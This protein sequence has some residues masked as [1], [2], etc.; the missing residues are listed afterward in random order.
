MLSKNTLSLFCDL[1]MNL[2][3]KEKQVEISRQ[4]LCHNLNFDAYQVFSYLDCES[5]NY[6]NEINLMTFLQKKN[7][8]P[9]T[10]EELQFFILLYDENSDAKL[11]YS[12]FLNI[13]LS[14]NN[15]ELRKKTRERI[16]SCYD[17]STIEFNIE[18]SLVKLFQKELDLIRTTKKII[19]EL[20]SRDDFNVHDLFHY[21]KGYSNITVESIKIFLEKNCREFDEKD[22][23]N[24]VKRLDINNDSKIDFSEFHQFLCFPNLKCNCC[25]FCQ[26]NCIISNKNLYNK[27]DENEENYSKFNI[28]ENLNYNYIREGSD[29]KTFPKISRN[30]VTINNYY[31][32]NKIN[33]EENENKFL[34]NNNIRNDNNNFLCQNYNDF[35]CCNCCP[36]DFICIDS[37]ISENKFLEYI[38]KLIIFE[39]KIEKAKIDLI[40]RPD[41]NI[42]DAFYIFC[43]SQ[44]KVIS[45]SDFKN[46]LK[47]FDLYPTSKEIKLIMRRADKDNKNYLNFDDFFYLL[48]PFQKEYRE[49]V[50]KEIKSCYKPK[51]NKSDVFLFCTKIYLSNLIRLIIECE[52][53]LNFIKENI[54]GINIYLE[55]IFNKI[56]KS[57]LGFISE[58]ELFLYLQNSGIKCNEIENGLIFKRLDKNKNE[59]IEIWEIEDELKS[60]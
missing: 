19:E 57:G 22:L 43:N 6:I 26:C 47:E 23:R 18:Y 38:T 52:S 48:T 55:N 21:L 16:G 59:K 25:S 10:M 49:K 13:V 30:F 20:K 35:Q 14:D 60:L 50:E 44:S 11:S 53:E 12:E 28:D 36:C 41:F 31:F 45:I 5:K 27:L 15:F 46:G 58:I 39:S 37:N 3:E 24:I 7:G 51:Y 2:S 54:I 17:N 33:P 56:D 40:K 42:E 9:C 8:I 4:V 1:L 32:T 29:V 34:Q